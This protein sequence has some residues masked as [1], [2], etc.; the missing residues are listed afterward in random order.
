MNILERVRLC[1]R[2]SSGSPNPSFGNPLTLRGSR[3]TCPLCSEF[4][5]SCEWRATVTPCHQSGSLSPAIYVKSLRASELSLGLSVQGALMFIS[6]SDNY[7]LPPFRAGERGNCPQPS[8]PR[9]AANSKAFFAS[10]LIQDAQ[11]A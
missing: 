1:P 7:S 8:S 3:D 11:E 9:L 4:S 10:L 6:S 2:R 5:I